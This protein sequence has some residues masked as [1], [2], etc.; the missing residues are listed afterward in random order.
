MGSGMRFNLASGAE[1]TSP[2]HSLG[3]LRQVGCDAHETEHGT[4]HV[5]FDAQAYSHIDVVPYAEMFRG[6]Q[7]CSSL[8][9][10]TEFEISGQNLPDVR[11]V[12]ARIAGKASE[13]NDKLGQAFERRIFELPGTE[14]VS[15][16]SAFDM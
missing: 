15:E 3:I 10:G 1:V 4:I 16:T 14:V 13:Q 2:H 11:D 7:G 6:F 5:K 8:Q 9:S 12:A